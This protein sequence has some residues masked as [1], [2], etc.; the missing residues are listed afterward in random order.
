[1]MQGFYWDVSPGGVW[2]DSLAYYSEELGKAGFDGI[3][4]PPPG[5]GFAGG[6]DVGYTPYDYYDL[7]EFNSQGTIAT[8]YGTR[9]QLENAINKLKAAGL[10]VYMDM[11][12][13]H[14]SG[15]TLEYNPYYNALRG[16][17][18]ASNYSGWG[19]THNQ[20]GIGFG[21]WDFSTS[22]S[23]SA[24]F[25]R[26]TS[27]REG[28]EPIDTDGNAFGMFSNGGTGTGAFAR[29]AFSHNADGELKPGES[30]SLDFSFRFNGGRRGID[31]WSN[32]NGTGFLANVEHAG[33]D[34][35]TFFPGAS[36]PAT[37]ETIVGNIFNKATRL[38][39]IWNG[40][41]S[42]NLTIR[43]ESLADN[44]F[45]EERTITVSSP[46]KS[47]TLLFE[48][49][50][51]GGDYEPF[52][53]NFTISNTVVASYAGSIPKS[54]STFFEFCS[55]VSASHAHIN[56]E[57]F[58][59]GDDARLTYTAFP[60]ATGS[61][62]IAWDPYDIN[63]PENSPGG[64]EF[65]YPNASNN[66][67]NTGDFYADNQLFDGQF[68]GFHQMFVNG[69]GY[70]NALH[71]GSGNTL[72][73]GQELKIWGDWLT[74]ELGIDGYRFDFVKG[75][76]P[77]YF[78]SFMKHGAMSGKFHV[79]ELY[80]GDMTR[81]TTYLSMLNTTDNPFSPSD[82]APSTAAI[83]D[84]N[85]RFTYRDMSTGGD[86]YDIRNFHSAGL[87][88]NGV[89]FDQI[90]TFV[91]NHDF[92]RLNF[93]GENTFTDGSHQPIIDKKILAYAHMLTHPGY[94]QV[95]WRDYFYYGLGDEIR[96]LVAIRNQFASGPHHMLTTSAGNPDWPGNQAVDE[97]QVY[98]MQ[99]EGIDDDTGLIMAIN[100]HSSFNINVWVDVINKPEWCGKQLV[101]LTGTISGPIQIQ[102]DCRVQ[103]ETM[104]NSYSVFVPSDYTFE[105]ASA[106][107][108]GQEGYRM[109]SV[110]VHTDF[111]TFLDPIWT[112]GAVN[113]ANNTGGTP[114]V[115]R[116]DVTAEGKDVGDWL[117]VTDLSASIEPGTGIMVYVYDLSENEDIDPSLALGFPKQLP[118]VGNE[119]QAPV[120]PAVNSHIDGWTLLGNP[121]S[122][123][124]DW[125]RVDKSA[126]VG[127]AVYVWDVNDGGGFPSDPDLGAVGTW[128]ANVAGL[129]EFDGMIRP[130]QGFFIRTIDDSETP[131][132]TF[133]NDSKLPGGNFFGKTRQQDFVRLELRGENMHNSAWLIFSENGSFEQTRQD[134][135]QL[136]S[137]GSHYAVIAARKTDGELYD[138]GS[139]PYP[140]ETFSVPVAI[141]T[142]YPGEYTIT[143]TDFKLPDNTTLFFVDRETMDAMPFESGFSYTFTTDATAKAVSKKVLSHPEKIQGNP[144]DG[145]DRFLTKGDRFLITSDP[146]LTQTDREPDLLPQK[147]SLH[148]NYPNPFNP[149]TTIVYELPEATD[150]TIAVYDLLGRRVATLVNGSMERG[151]HKVTFDA[152]GLSSGVYLYTMQAGQISINRKL[153]IVK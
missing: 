48:N 81:K 90:V 135:V 121:F 95:W 151:R 91:E 17:D 120:S 38:T 138:I 5:K 152:T 53:N 7:G 128:K 72:P 89:P 30:F 67:G 41:A 126:S 149:S 142:T 141:E 58:P 3:W 24:G 18:D 124:I 27:V 19:G 4:M 12:L 94:A 88:N 118:A 114:N 25:F 145:G 55:D 66:P 125:S 1:M 20:G 2:Y 112:Q 101:D 34:A 87:F 117:P 143:V 130:F 39:F 56:C 96:R 148:Q 49:T 85:L 107:L 64:S 132:V 86:G 42:D 105:L 83:F 31:L 11:V 147:V 84:F 100:K 74:T 136:K 32:S 102:N 108:E 54:G 62:E 63:D 77:E 93:E 131:Q 111:A 137:L 69:F 139:Y 134:A 78:K 71:D 79:H 36:N 16:I 47:F 75:I 98:V 35:L 140:D 6:F 26:G 127:E 115:Y 52:F 9:A 43:A 44:S 119:I 97:Q 21:E 28:R 10:E 104:A 8:R 123:A 40:G 61:G 59:E 23:G 110:P 45:S 122:T 116:W 60:L 133:T 46:P 13:N 92:D 106:V 73:L 33:S 150:V 113:G 82:P 129:G 22:G 57:D 103:I 50:I 109:L 15:G 76:H 37:R 99:R 65:F 144:E 80:D 68:G 14:R 51:S 146:N 153:T 29:R 70:D